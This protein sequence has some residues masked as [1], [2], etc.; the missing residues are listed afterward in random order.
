MPHSTKSETGRKGPD[1]E[2]RKTIQNSLGLLEMAL[3][4][5]SELQLM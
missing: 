4:H 2:V 1:F 5:D 3:S